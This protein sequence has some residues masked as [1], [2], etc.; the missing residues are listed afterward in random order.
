MITFY[1]RGYEI[2]AQASFNRDGGLVAYDD[3]F[4]DDLNTGIST[5]KFSIDKTTEEAEKIA[6]GLYIRVLTHDD[7]K[8]WFE[9]MD[10]DEDN[11]RMDITAVDAGIDLIGESVWP[12]EADKAYD[13]RHYLER[14]MYD[15]GWLLTISNTIFQRERKLK[16]E[17]F[18]T[19]S[20]RIRQIA[21]GFGAEIE[22][23][24]IEKNGKP[25]QKYVNIVEKMGKD[26]EIRL[27]YG[28]EIS[29]IKKRSSI[30]N[31]ATAL[32]GHG[33]E[34]LTLEGYSYNDGRYWVG[35][36]TIHDLREGARWSRHADVAKDGGY[37]VSTYESEATT[38]ERLFQETLA[39]LK[40]RAYPEVE[41][42]IDFSELPEEVRKG[43]TVIIVD[44][45]FKPA[46]KLKARVT[47]IEC[48][49][50][51]GFYGEGR[52]IVSNI[53][54]RG[55]SVDE[56]LRTV[57][58]FLKQSTFDFSKVPAVAHIHSEKGTVFS[59][60]DSA[61]TTLVAKVTRF[62]IDTTSEYT[63]KWKRV[64]AKPTEK[65]EQ[66][67]AENRTSNRIEITK[68]DI[69]VQAEFICEFYKNGALELTKG[70]VLKDLTIN[71]Y[72]G[73]TAPKNPQSGDFWTDTSGQK[74]V[75]KVYTNGEWK[76]VISDNADNIDK[77][78]KEWELNN[79]E[80][81]D[82]L[83]KI[84]QELESVKEEEKY[85]RDLTGRFGDLEK[86]YKR[87]LEQEKTIEKLGERQKAYELT[88][89]QS[90]AII[91]T[92][93]TFFNFSD[94]GLEI[95]KKGANMKMVLKND[96]V[97]FLDGGKLTAYMSGQK[98][99]I[100]SGAFWQSINIGNHTFEKFG[101][102]YTIVS[103]SGSSA[104]ELGR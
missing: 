15:S 41:Y 22:Y 34:G 26:K 37:I 83:T 54:K 11:G 102:E 50:S 99:F 104:M 76:P 90:S 44:Y 93:G 1:S 97:E 39:Q 43:D 35:G 55:I 73:D 32:R 86:A 75:L 2:V 69:N 59:N 79:R 40:K 25:V 68:E 38:K 70:I 82:K 7:R 71:K 77:F 94:D 58:K 63:F 5:F 87:I 23:E 17:G 8:L 12:Y 78:K 48:S 96:R 33:A 62:D 14:D 84:I 47:E 30:Q 103:Y 10:I 29:N 80:Y 101:D 18:E 4:H 81:A 49:L 65:D 61:R 57:E 51:K 52:V 45:D 85:T 66:W 6:L 98:M 21:R 88:L 95:G 92:F 64:S 13:I 31:L 53:E 24:I 56:Q 20:K 67:N 89:E 19:A 100:V 3:V 42:E 60:T 36:D 9:I 16:F 72:K 46:L 74:E 91:S 27:E 28:R